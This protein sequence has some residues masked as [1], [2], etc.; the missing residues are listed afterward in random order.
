MAVTAAQFPRT[1]LSSK[2]LSQVASPAGRA[3]DATALYW[4]NL[5]AVPGKW[6]EGAGKYMEKV[7]VSGFLDGK[8]HPT[9]TIVHPKAVIFPLIFPLITT[10]G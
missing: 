6:L 10:F 4:A 5:K 1:L 8:I 9:W 7:E 3:A 2:T